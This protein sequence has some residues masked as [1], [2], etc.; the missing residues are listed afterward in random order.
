MKDDCVVHNACKDED[1][2]IDLQCGQL[3]NNVGISYF[4]LKLEQ[5]NLNFL[6]AIQHSKTSLVWCN[7][8]YER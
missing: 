2:S 5:V 6:E 8:D 7:L 1:R 3:T 4:S